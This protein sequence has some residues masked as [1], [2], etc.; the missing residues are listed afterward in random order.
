M[1]W[2][3]L[4]H[5]K[6]LDPWA[7]MEIDR[8]IFAAI[9]AEHT[10]L[11][12]LRVYRWDRECVSIGRH[13]SEAAVREVYANL[14]TVRRPTGGRAVVHG[15]DLTLSVVTH[16][17]WLPYT[18]DRSVMSSY[19][20]IVSGIIQ[21]LESIGIAAILGPME[22]RFGRVDQEFGKSTVDCFASVASCDV[23][24]RASGGKLL[25]SAQRREQGVILQQMSIPCGV[26]SDEVRFLETLRFTL[27]TPLGVESW[28]SV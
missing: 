10:Q 16:R 22:R 8:K 26:L 11:P 3:W 15:N 12:V 17:D 1:H 2:Q 14:P 28:I 6:P 4:E 7:N 25:G 21:A 13:Q 9:I 23:S 20:Q 5:D 18:T 19:R 27:K 24:D